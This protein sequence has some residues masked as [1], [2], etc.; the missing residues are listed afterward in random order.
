MTAAKK[1]RKVKFLRRMKIAQAVVVVVVVV[2]IGAV[3]KVKINVV[4]PKMTCCEL[5]LSNILRAAPERNKF[6]RQSDVF[7]AERALRCPCAACRKA[8][9]DVRTLPTKSYYFRCMWQNNRFTYKAFQDETIELRPSSNKTFYS[10]CPIRVY[11]FFVYFIFW[12]FERRH[13]A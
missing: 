8:S 2:I 5:M 11:T 9:K 12:V 7:Q 3:W 6:R 13:L 4:N 1:D 10:P